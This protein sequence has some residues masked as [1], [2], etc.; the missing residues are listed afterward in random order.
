MSNIASFYM[1][2]RGTRENCESFIW[3]IPADTDITEEQGTKD[4]SMFFICGECDNGMKYSFFDDSDSS[5]EKCAAECNIEF[6]AYCSDLGEPDWF[7]HYHY[8]GA[9]CIAHDYFQH[10]Y[11]INPDDEEEETRPSPEI[12]EKY[13]DHV[14]PDVYSLKGE[15]L[16][17]S[18][19][20]ETDSFDCKFT[21]S[22]DD[23]K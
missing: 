12:L 20:E 19:N 22:F 7:E 18:Y 17:C 11:C 23:L 4:D 2:V 16:T 1:R 5:L 15:Y 13:Y 10:F 21:M 3:K 6:E 9:E 14:Q 8:K